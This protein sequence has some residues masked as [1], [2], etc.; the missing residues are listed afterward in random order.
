MKHV[1]YLKSWANES[2]KLVK[3]QRF[4]TNESMKHVTDLKFWTN[5]SM[6]QAKDLKFWTNK[7]MKLAKDLKFWTNKSMT[8][9]KDLKFWTTHMTCEHLL[10]VLI[11]PTPRH[12]VIFSLQMAVLVMATG[13]CLFVT[14]LAF[15]S[16]QLKPWGSPGAGWEGR[17][18]SCFPTC[19]QRYPP[20]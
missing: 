8:Q 10:Q 7:S 13:I 12:T 11:L 9:V 16:S 6:K 18:H 17:V 2:V 4:W 14:M 5:K 15:L 1:K 19:V 20:L 3:D